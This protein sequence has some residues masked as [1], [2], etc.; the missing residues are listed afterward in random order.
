MRTIGFLVFLLL[1]GVLVVG[2][3][4]SVRAAPTA[5]ITVTTTADEVNTNGFCSLREA[6]INANTDSQSGSTD[7]AAGSGADTIL[8][9]AAATYTLSK[10]D[11]GGGHVTDSGADN[12][13]L[14]ITSTITIQGNGATIERS[15]TLTCTLDGTA[16]DGEF[17]IFEV[18]GA[19]EH[20]L[21][22]Q[23]LTVRGGCAD[24]SDSPQN[25]GGGIRNA[26]TVTLTN[27][28]LSGNRAGFGGA[29]SN[30]GTLTIQSSTVSGNSAPND[31]GGI[32]ND[33]ILTITNSTISDNSADYD[34]GGIY[35]GGGTV[36]ITNSTISDND[37]FDDGGGIE[38]VGGEVTVTNST[39]SE[40]S[41]DEDGGGI[42]NI[43]DNLVGVGTMTITNSTISGNSADEDG[44]GILNAGILDIIG[45]TISGN[46]AD[47][48]GGG[49]RNN[50]TGTVIATNSTISGNNADEDG[51]GIWND[52]IAKLS[53]TTIASN[54]AGKFG[55]GIWNDHNVFIKNSIVGNNTATLAGPNCSLAGGTF[56]PDGVNLATDTA[57]MSC[58]T[59]NFTYVPST[60][61]GGL[62]LDPLAVNAP[63]TTATH[64][65]L[66][67]SV[68]ID[69]VPSGQCTDVNTDPVT[70]DQRGV[71]RPQDGDGN[72]TATCDVGAYEAPTLQRMTFFSLG[73]EDGRILESGENTDAGGTLSTTGLLRVGDDA[74]NRQYRS[75]LSFDTSPLPNTA[76]IVGVRLE[77]KRQG[78]SGGGNPVQAFGGFLVDLRKGSLGPTSGLEP[79]DFAA[80]A[81]KT[82]GPLIPPL[83]DGWYRLLLTGGKHQINK[84][85]RTQ[86]RLR[87]VQDD[88]N[89]RVANYVSLSAGEAG[90]S[91]RPRLV[92]EYVMP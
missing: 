51:G 12:D 24:G 77:L 43:S 79:A 56:V 91:N 84:V 63:G 49:I 38:N 54:S 53:F 37:A 80:A 71:S 72:G 59:T 70:Q 90:V 62:N 9:A 22:L 82:V 8:L 29:S 32:W 41:A 4:L 21:T 23:N 81:D 89:D 5:T 34:G 27:S 68:A 1:C 2:L 46:S 87:F 15:T 69:A 78:V 86:L 48:D 42:R 39:I 85:G 47:E 76:V 74:A 31:G 28:T 55:G 58:G 75:V 73:A 67:G 7:C 88:N 11:D 19:G 64:A 36:T 92:V 25:F 35:N 26:G 3:G 13:D 57:T 17:R 10:D 30:E 16:N 61:P 20:N 40:N 65:L 45:S 44:G 18:Q 33:D 6:I 50:S 52:G 14:D 66:A 60:G 83:V